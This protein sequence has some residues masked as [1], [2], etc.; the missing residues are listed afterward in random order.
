M[1][2]ASSSSEMKERAF[3]P[4]LWRR[5]RALQ[6][7]ASPGLLAA[8][9]CGSGSGL[10][11]RRWMAGAKARRRRWAEERRCADDQAR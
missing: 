4:G 9:A 6:A 5:R 11:V 10:A 3:S 8:L 7:P 1:K 2:R